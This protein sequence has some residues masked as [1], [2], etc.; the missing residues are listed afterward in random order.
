MKIDSCLFTF[1][2]PSNR[3]AHSNVILA[4]GVANASWSAINYMG[5]FHRCRSTWNTRPACL[6]WAVSGSARPSRSSCW[7]RCTSSQRLVLE[8]LQGWIS[9]NY[10]PCLRITSYVMAVFVF[11]VVNDKYILCIHTIKLIA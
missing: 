7:R 10:V 8:H 6:L 3:C 1:L 5:T 11:V 9:D 2:P 4:P